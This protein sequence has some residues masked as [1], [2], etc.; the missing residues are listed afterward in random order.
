MIMK[1]LPKI[2][3]LLFSILLFGYLL[4]PS[5]SFPKPIPGSVQSQEGADV[6]TPL[7]TSY[8]T[9]YL[10][11][12]VLDYYQNQFTRS[13]F[14]NLPMPTLRLNYPPE[15]AQTLVRDQ[16]HSVYLQEI[17]HPL[18]ESLFVNGFTYQI[19][20]NTIEYKGGVYQEIVTVKF[21]PSS[22]FARL[23][24]GLMIVFSIVLVYREAKHLCQS[25]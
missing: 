7:R 9:D 6:E 5:Y 4:L 3:L 20:N 13:S 17:V 24:V 23:V 10:R 25:F 1:W 8:F 15:D 14:L 11:P 12:Q 16:T 19:Q 2:A 18:R 22:L 21:V